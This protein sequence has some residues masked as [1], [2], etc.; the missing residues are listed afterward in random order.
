MFNSIIDKSK[1]DTFIEI[2]NLINSRY[3]DLKEL[4]KKIL[5]SATRLTEG[6][7]GSL[8]LVDNA[9]NC[10]KFEIALGS[11]G[12]AITG[13]TI[14]LGEGIAGWVALKNSSLIVHDVQDDSRH[15]EGISKS[16]GFE[17]K[18]IL[19]APMRVKD[20]CLGV[21]EIINKKSSEKYFTKEDLEWLE[22]FS[23][24]AGIA[25]QN[26]QNFKAVQDELS[27]LKLAITNN[28]DTKTLIFKSSIMTDVL[29]LARKYAVS[30]STVLIIGESGTGKE[31]IGQFLHSES[32][33]KNGP[34]IKINCAAIPEHLFE[35][36][37]F[38]HVKGAFT[39]AV[40]DRVGKF[41]LAHGGS[42]FLDEISEIPLSSQAKFL[43]LLQDK[44]IE[45]VGG[46]TAI[47][48][49]VRIIAATNKDL[50][51]LVEKGLFRK[52]LFYRLN[53]LPLTLPPLRRRREDLPL[54]ID[55][56]L[57]RQ[58]KKLQNKV[59]INGQAMDYLLRY[60]WPG[61]IRELENTIERA[62]ILAQNFEIM[63]ADLHLKTD[64]F[65]SAD[66][67]LDLKDAIN[68]FKAIYIR[69]ILA[70]NEWNQTKAASVLN[71]QRTYLSK[72]MKE[73]EINSTGEN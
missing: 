10:L 40:E 66:Q 37:L 32:S 54:L 5:E 1:F 15:F 64:T 70:E 61:N 59:T 3:K 39:D 7:A 29:A 43:R 60:D 9:N 12:E 48:T 69:R 56:F 33:R 67:K 18:S 35:S 65:D 8:L 47:S 20:S 34:I 31:L 30:D 13:L 36:E 42:I 71:I 26:A 62:S 14:P 52:D 55:Y 23:N 50:G 2:N 27:E 21:I 63:L 28:A 4:L 16:V 44:K 19:A 25:I 72:L 22:I 53:V 17:T 41:E 6:E 46:S 68:Q 45:R 24:Q 49:D 58:S 11:K 51:A 73:L 38:G 57:T